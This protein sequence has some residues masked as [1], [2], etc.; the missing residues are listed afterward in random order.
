MLL[1]PDVL[2]HPLHSTVLLRGCTVLNLE[3]TPGFLVSETWYVPGRFI[4]LSAFSVSAKFT[5]ALLSVRGSWRTLQERG[6]PV[7]LARMRL[8]LL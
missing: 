1:L 5:V 2:G 4:C 3:R 6:A 7:Y 8:C